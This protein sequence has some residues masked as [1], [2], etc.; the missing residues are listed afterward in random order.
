MW[1]AVMEAQLI[2]SGYVEIVIT[3]ELMLGII[4]KLS[5]DYDVVVSSHNIEH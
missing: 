4:I 2:Q 5:K 3:L 1:G